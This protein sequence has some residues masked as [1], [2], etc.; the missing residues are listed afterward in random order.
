[1]AELAGMKVIPAFDSAAVSVAYECAR[2]RRFSA[3]KE[4]TKGLSA[5]SSATIHCVWWLL[6]Q[7]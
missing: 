2:R 4:A 5:S 6:L 1:M 7:K 3:R